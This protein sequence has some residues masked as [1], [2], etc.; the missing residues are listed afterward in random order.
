MLIREIISVIVFLCLLAPAVPLAFDIRRESEYSYFVFE[1]NFGFTVH[2]REVTPEGQNVYVEFHFYSVNSA[3]EEEVNSF[4]RDNLLLLENGTGK[5]YEPTSVHITVNQTLFET[6]RL[7]V[8]YKYEGDFAGGCTLALKSGGGKRVRLDL[9]P[10][11]HDFYR[12]G[13][14]V[15]QEGLDV[16]M[17]P[18]D[19][20]TVLRRLDRG[21]TVYFTGRVSYFWPDAGQTWYYCVDYGEVF[22]GETRGWAVSYDNN[23]RLDYRDKYDKEPP[24]DMFLYIKRGS[25]SPR[26][27]PRG[28]GETAGV[29]EEGKYEE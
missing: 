23:K 25:F 10:A 2:G 15:A 11:D 19:R 9:G 6:A 12:T 7:F 14:V 17:A 21:D 1:S 8:E 24:E 27:V 13:T 28:R 3:C 5:A 29:K 4:C 22:C 26:P 18:N 16:Y 20:S